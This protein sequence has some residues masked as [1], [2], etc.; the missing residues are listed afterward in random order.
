MKQ[1]SWLVLLILTSA[2]SSN[3]TQATQG[4]D[5]DAP[6][7]TGATGGAVQETTVDDRVAKPTPGSPTML[8]R[9]WGKTR[10]KI[11]KGKREVGTYVQKNTLTKLDGD[12][13]IEFF[14]Y[15]IYESSGTEY[16]FQTVCEVTAPYDLRAIAGQ[17]GY[18][19]MT[20]EFKNGR[21]L[22]QTLGPTG[23]NLEVPEHFITDFSLLRGLPRMPLE[24]GAKAQFDY[25]DLQKLPEE[26]AVQRG[27]LSCLGRE[28]VATSEGVY[29][30]WKLKWLVDE[31]RPMFLW[32][33]DEGQ[34][35]KRLYKREEWLLDPN[36]EVE[37]PAAPANQGANSKGDRKGRKKGKKKSER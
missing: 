7:A 19:N 36:D 25:V 35:I 3:A 20:L 23:V 2:V 34:L 12:D 6:G 9:R 30:T 21:A 28:K 37:I 15:V 1:A 10:Y 26:S 17:V 33:G 16:T 5:G 13:V 14:D 32:Y 4:T 22:G 29:D 27:T 24:V 11:T 8:A 18:G 31:T